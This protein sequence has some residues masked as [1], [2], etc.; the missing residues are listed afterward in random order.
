MKDAVVA[1]PGVVTFAPRGAGES[2]DESD[3]EFDDESDDEF[4]DESCA[5]ESDDESD[6]ESR[7][8]R[9]AFFCAPPFCCDLKPQKPLRR[10]LLGGT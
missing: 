3:D 2:D 5:G 7:G 1:A 4:D 6:G 10:R 8:C 9:A